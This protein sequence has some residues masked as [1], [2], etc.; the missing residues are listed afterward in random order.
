MQKPG[1]KDQM[2]LQEDDFNMERHG[3]FNFSGV[4]NHIAMSIN[5]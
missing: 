2:K 3:H 5:L 4:L 1:R